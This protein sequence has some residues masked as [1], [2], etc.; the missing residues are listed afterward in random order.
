MHGKLDLNITANRRDRSFISR[1]NYLFPFKILRPFYLDGIGTAF[2]YVLDAAGGMLAGDHLD[3]RIRVNEGAH[4]YLTNASTA[5]SYPMSDGHAKI[6][7][8]FSIGKN[9]SLEYFPE[10]IMLLKDT[11]VEVNTRIDGDRDS[12]FAFCEMYAGGRKHA[13][14]LFQFRSMMNRFEII[15]DGKLAIWENYRLDGEKLRVGR[16]GNLET[17]THWGNLYMYANDGSAGMLQIVQEC[18]AEINGHA[19]WVGCSLH[20]SSVITVKALSLE[21]EVIKDCFQKVWARLRPLMLKEELP[22]IRK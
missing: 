11:S 20:P 5:K 12:V 10:E 15:I 6:D 13:G 8:Y 3:Y 7:Q 16:L 19:I 22:Y 9:A 1:M 14:E 21:Y 18:L 17:Y 2:V 4:L